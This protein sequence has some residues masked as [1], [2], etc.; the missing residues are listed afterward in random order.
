MDVGKSR[1]DEHYNRCSNIRK[2]TDKVKSRKPSEISDLERDVFTDE[3]ISRFEL[4]VTPENE[5]QQKQIVNELRQ[6][7]NESLQD[8]FSQAQ[9]ILRVIGP[10]DTFE[11]RGI[12]SS[13][14]K[15]VIEIIVDRFV[16]GIYDEELNARAVDRGAAFSRSLNQAFE[17]IQG[18]HTTIADQAKQNEMWQQI[19][20]A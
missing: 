6:S 1:L 11:H 19:H 8:Y 4:V 12:L 7:K 15:F 9:G 20:K 14:N 5:P 16:L 17:V 13:I 18:C 10:D 2:I 3:F